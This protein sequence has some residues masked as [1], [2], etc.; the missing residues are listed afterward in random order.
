MKLDSG[1]TLTSLMIYI[2][3]MII[4]IGV[5]A[6]FTSFFYKNVNV[7]DFNKETSQFT[8]FSAMFSKEIN[9]QGNYIVDFKPLENDGISYI[10]FAS[11]NQITFLNDNKSLYKNKVKICGSVELCS[12][13]VSFVDSKFVINVDFRADGVDLSGENAIVYSKF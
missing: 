3:G 8:A 13:D 11:G 12:F 5:V 2:I 9:K 7:E 6:T 1:V 4:V 10:I